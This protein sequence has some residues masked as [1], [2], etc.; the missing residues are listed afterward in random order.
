M[1]LAELE[2]K[3]AELSYKEKAQLVQRLAEELGLE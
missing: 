2:E 3:I 1:S